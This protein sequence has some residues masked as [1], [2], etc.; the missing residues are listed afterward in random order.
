MYVFLWAETMIVGRRDR[1]GLEK[2]PFMIGIP[3][4]LG[5]ALRLMGFHPYKPGNTLVR[6]SIIIA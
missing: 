2:D 6:S 3:L 1:A 4:A 5:F